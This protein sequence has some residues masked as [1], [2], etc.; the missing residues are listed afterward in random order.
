MSVAWCYDEPIRIESSSLWVGICFPWGLTSFA[1][2][3]HFRLHDLRRLV[4]ATATSLSFVQCICAS[5]HFEKSYA[6]QR[7]RLGV[8]HSSFAIS[9]YWFETCV[10]LGCRTCS[11]SV[12]GSNLVIGLSP[13]A[14]FC[15][16]RI[17]RNVGSL[18][19]VAWQPW[20]AICFKVFY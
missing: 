5:L 1:F 13:V 17:G 7:I 3:K 9:R 20:N 19:S 4:V 10:A 8:L 12:L 14:H 15:I 11:M 2:F 6:A 18:K 16:E